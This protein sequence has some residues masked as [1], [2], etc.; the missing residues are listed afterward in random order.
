MNHNFIS[1]ELY[2]YIWL[3]TA[4]HNPLGQILLQRTYL[5]NSDDKVIFARVAELWLGI[6]LCRYTFLIRSIDIAPFTEDKFTNL[7]QIH[8]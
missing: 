7:A 5:I 6:L 1:I 2:F 3:S 4:S 8:E